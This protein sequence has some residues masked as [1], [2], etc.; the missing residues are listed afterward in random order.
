MTRETREREIL[1]NKGNGGKATTGMSEPGQHRASSRGG[2]GILAPKMHRHR[3]CG[4]RALEDS[5][6]CE[7]SR[8]GDD[9]RP[10]SPAPFGAVTEP[11]QSRERERGL[12]RQNFGRVLARAR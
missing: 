2:D 8:M 7:R 5:G 3:E 4:G 1:W 10:P 11:P 12:G 6:G 9:F